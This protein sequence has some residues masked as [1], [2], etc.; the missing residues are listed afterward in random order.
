MMIEDPAMGHL[1]KIHGNLK[2][3]VK[4]SNDYR[5]RMLNQLAKYARLNEREKFDRLAY[6][7]ARESKAFRQSMI[8]E[9]IPKI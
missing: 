6:I 2:R 1:S 8:V 3:A 7:I 5:A 4:K 9:T